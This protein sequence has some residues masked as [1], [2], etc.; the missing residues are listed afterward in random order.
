[1]PHGSGLR[2]HGGVLVPLQAPSTNPA[3]NAT[4]VTAIPPSRNR[5]D[6]GRAKKFRRNRAPNP[7]DENQT[8]LPSMA[9]APNHH[10]N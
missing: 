7:S 4:M 6:M 10:C 8:M 9:P 5:Q 2:G 1:M 3:P